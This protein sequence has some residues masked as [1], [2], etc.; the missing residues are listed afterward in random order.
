MAGLLGRGEDNGVEMAEPGPSS[1]AREKQHGASVSP[2]NSRQLLYTANKLLREWQK[3]Q[4]PQEG[5]TATREHRASVFFPGAAA[6]RVRD[7][8]WNFSSCILTCDLGQV[9]ESF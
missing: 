1:S 6:I 5:D 9:S 4:R 3:G 7:L 2:P 8:C